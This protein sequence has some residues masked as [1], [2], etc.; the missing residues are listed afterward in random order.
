M[1]TTPFA[2]TTL[3]ACAWTGAATAASF[4]AQYGWEDGSGTAFGVFPSSSTTFANVAAGS[5]TDYG[6]G[7]GPVVYNVTPNEG[8]RMLEITELDTTA[9]N[10]DVTI[11]WIDGL[12]AGDTFSFS[13][14]AFDPTDGRS[15]SVL[16]GAVYTNT[17]P[18]SFAGYATPFQNFD[19][20][21][22][23][24]WLTLQADAVEDSDTDPPTQGIQEVFTFDPGTDRTGVALQARLFAQ[25]ASQP[26]NGG[27]GTYKFFIDNLQVT[28]NSSNPNAKIVFIDGT[29][30]GVPEPSSLA[31]LGLGGL[32]IARRRNG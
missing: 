30:V 3:I 5:E 24:G 7:G 12:L 25:S 29:E 9:R 8:N 6:T 31:L 13:F 28:V 26:G 27:P 23:S 32:L 19:N 14:D 2:T 16:P 4:S 1:K 22:G 21:P 10:P 20:Y 17:G 15:P 11:G 18:T